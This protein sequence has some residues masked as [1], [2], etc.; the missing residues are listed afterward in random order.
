MPRKRLI[1]PEFFTDGELYDAEVT[2]G[3]PLR[4]AYAGLW[5]QAD[6]RGF[7]EWRP[8]ELKLHVLPHDPV[9]M[10]STMLALCSHG[11]IKVFEHPNHPGKLFGVIP[12]FARWQTFHINE[13]PNL[14]IPQPLTDADVTST[15]PASFQH[16]AS[17]S[18]TGTVV[19]AGTVTGTRG[20]PRAKR[21]NTKALTNTELEPIRLAH[22]RVNFPGAFTAATAK[23]FRA[24]WTG[25]VRH[26]GAER[27][28]RIWEASQ[29]DQAQRR[30][31]TIAKVAANPSMFDPD[32]IVDGEEAA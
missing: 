25:L 31:H 6:R 10:L 19:I 17:T 24:H 12:N 3:L 30:F 2:S 4:V 26:L 20:K 29:R 14:Y 1:S 13:K 11:Y 9:D 23:A 8:R 21:A 27:C 18:V 15:V 16:R 7:F 22:E 32:R 28:A 5:C